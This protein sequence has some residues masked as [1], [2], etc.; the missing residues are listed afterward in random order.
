MGST[1]EEL[2]QGNRRMKRALKTGIPP[3]PRLAK[4]ETR[5][6]RAERKKAALTKKVD[7]FRTSRLDVRSIYTLDVPIEAS[8]L[9][10]GLPRV[11]LG[12]LWLGFRLLIEL[13]SAIWY[14]S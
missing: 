7:D 3:K 5:Q 6:A 12:L 13:V 14:S 4:K 8:S 2:V 11:G 1:V 10:A 9:R